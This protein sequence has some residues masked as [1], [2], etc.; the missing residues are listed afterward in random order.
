MSLEFMLKKLEML[1]TKHVMVAF[2]RQAVTELLEWACM[3]AFYYL[4]AE[5]Y[6]S[7]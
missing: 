7:H 4:E 5:K 6:L 2:F 3:A 1:K